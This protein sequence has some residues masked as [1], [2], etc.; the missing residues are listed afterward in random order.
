[1]KLKE[2]NAAPA[3][4]GYGEAVDSL[5]SE[6]ASREE[7]LESLKRQLRDMQV[8]VRREQQLISSAWYD[9]LHKGL[10]ENVMTQHRR[11]APTS[12]LG[13]QRNVFSQQLGV[14]G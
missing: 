11:V 9:Q 7:E 5:R 13:V 6:L 12:W 4:E 3:S 10:R 2:S 14:R 1:M 8:Q